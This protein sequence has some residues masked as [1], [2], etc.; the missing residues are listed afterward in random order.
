MCAAVSGMV[1]VI[2]A[3]S[4]SHSGITADITG[5]SGLYP[6]NHLQS[7]EKDESSKEVASH[8]R[9][10][11]YSCLKNGSL[12]CPH[13][14]FCDTNNGTCKCPQIPSRAL[15]CD[16][17][18]NG[19]ALSVLDCNCV[20]YNEEFNETEVGFCIYNCAIY[21]KKNPIDV[22]YHSF[23]P[24]TS[25]WNDFLC[26][27]FNRRGTLCGRCNEEDGFYPR[28]YSFDMTCIQCTNGKSNWWKYV[29]SVYLPLT[30]FY[31]VILCFKINIHTSQLQGYVLYSQIISVPALSHVVYLTTQSKPI[32]FQMVKFIGSLY[33]IWNMDFFRMYNT[34]ICLQTD[35]LSTLA[36][37]LATAV[38][39]LLLMA[40]TFMMVSLYDYN[41]KLIVIM[42]KPFRA[43]F[44]LFQRNWNI[45][46]STV[47]A[48][49]T[50][51][52]LTNIKFLSV[53]FNFLAPVR[54]YQFVKPE[55][56]VNYTLRLYYDATIPYFRSAHLPYAIVAIM[57]MFFF[58][59]T[60][61]LIIIVYPIKMCHKCFHILPH[62]GQIFL[63]TFM[64]S[65]QGCYKDGTERGTQDCRWFLSVLFIFRFILIAIYGYTVNSM[66]FPYAAMVS[67]IT[68]MI[69]IVADPFKA[70]QSH[71]SSIMT[72]F[73]LFIA[74][75]YTCIAVINMGERKSNFV[76]IYMLYSLMLLIGVLP[77]IYISVLI[78][79]WIFHRRKFGL[80]FIRGVN[81]WRQLM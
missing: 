19:N 22:V 1:V 51:L 33:G 46:T 3:L 13:W 41:F 47:D 16:G 32:V 55:L 63:H 80:Y 42:W 8:F 70:R 23:P 44:S 6:Y 18:E 60:P 77:H 21:I 48:L 31:L 34:G 24:N 4:F 81:A 28:A 49:A 58:V 40:V 2:V 20:T 62:R 79:Y 66:Y 73:L 59:T 39:P 17:F 64:D 72:T 68:A 78:L 57:A 71:L 27:K 15:K 50:F 61:T 75:F 56:T 25:D 14:T 37:E 76:V 43:F 67:V 5:N 74:A 36:L 29:L 45:R 69:A 52:F 35:T 30:L 54:V 65:F 10:A 12:P 26:S 9:S 38:Y 7:Q 53:C 11:Q